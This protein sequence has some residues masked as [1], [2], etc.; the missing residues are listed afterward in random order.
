[1]CCRKRKINLSESWKVY[2]P[3]G[4]CYVCGH[5]YVGLCINTCGNIYIPLSH[6][7]F[8]VVFKD[9]CS[10][11]LNIFGL[12]MMH[13]SLCYQTMPGQRCMEN[14]CNWAVC[15]NRTKKKH[16]METWQGNV[17]CRDSGNSLFIPC[18]LHRHGAEHVTSATSQGDRVTSGE[19]SYDVAL[20]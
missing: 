6:T 16:W 20:Y 11:K 3:N 5:L 8:T 15:E 14:I 19:R 4:K 9:L 18:L 1:M 7:S 17:F 12:E 2:V 10:L 13:H